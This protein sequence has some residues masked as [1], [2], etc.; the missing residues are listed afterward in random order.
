MRER[1]GNG[2]SGQY[3]QFGQIGVRQ[4]KASRAETFGSSRSLTKCKSISA[5]YFAI[6]LRLI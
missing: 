4:R 3:A 5:E 1:T 6:S 2:S